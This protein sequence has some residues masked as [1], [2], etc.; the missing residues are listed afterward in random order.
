LEFNM[1]RT[2]KG[3]RAIAILVAFALIQVTFQ[4]GLAESSNSIPTISPQQTLLGRITVKGTSAVQVNGVNVESGDSIASGVIVQ[5]PEGAESRVDLGP[6]G[7][8]EFESGSRARLDF[9]CPTDKPAS[10]EN[11]RLNVTLLAGCV[12]TNYPQGTHHRIEDAN[13]N[14]K[15]ESDPAK[16][17]NGGGVLRVCHDGITP[18]PATGGGLS[19]KGLLA[20]I[21]GAGG[22]GTI[23]ALAASGENPS[24]SSPSTP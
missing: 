16:E 17:K 6:L 12:V 13:H 8:V 22:A 11:C 2:R 14:K 15:A 19:K 5:V 1:D 3:L 9:S 21:L 10:P 20:I 18:V 4:L 23:I 7:S 24:P